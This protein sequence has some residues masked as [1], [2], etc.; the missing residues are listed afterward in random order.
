MVNMTPEEAYYK[1]KNENR[2]IPEL[3]DVI[4]T[5]SKYSYRY[6]INII[7]GRWEKGE[8]SISTNSHYSY[9]YVINIINCPFELGHRAIFNS[10]YKNE[11]IDFL[12]SIN[13]DL[14]EIGEWLI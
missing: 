13:Y 5:D 9:W 3:E 11:Y 4:A 8:R 10:H 12:K 7:K 14:S 1:C 2:R 6:A